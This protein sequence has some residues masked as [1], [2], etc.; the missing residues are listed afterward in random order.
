MQ[1]P[2][3]TSGAKNKVY[4]YSE[5][6]HLQTCDVMG[7]VCC[8]VRTGI[9]L[10]VSRQKWYVPNKQKEVLTEPCIIKSLVYVHVNLQHLYAWPKKTIAS[11]FSYPVHA[12]SQPWNSICTNTYCPH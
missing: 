12:A 6:R 1:K 11:T 8:R 9:C 10:H 3:K 4:K 5:S 2:C 7:C